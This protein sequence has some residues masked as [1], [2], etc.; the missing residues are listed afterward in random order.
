MKN[1]MLI[2]G[3]KALAVTAGVLAL[4]LIAQIITDKMP[5]TLALADQEQ[6]SIAS[7]ES[8][9]ESTD[10]F[11][12]SV[13]KTEDVRIEKIKEYLTKRNAPL[14]KYA[15]EFVSAADTY[16]IDYRIV[17]AISIIESGGG[18]STFKPYN[19]WGWGNMIFSSWED[20]IWTVSKGISNYYANGLKTPKTIAYTYCPPN[21]EKWGSNVQYV[22]NQIEAM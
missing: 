1:Q 10:D 2:K 8:I 13:D 16:N 4:G 14:A 17:A 18:K 12:I 3:R 22:M 19:A 20:G 21:A 15:Q 9:S 6:V 11:E 5:V 7:T